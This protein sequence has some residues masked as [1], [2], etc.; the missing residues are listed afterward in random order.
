[1]QR[2]SAK[3]QACCESPYPRDEVPLKWFYKNPEDPNSKICK[4]CWHCRQYTSRHKKL[5]GAIKKEA[6]MKIKEELAKSN[7]NVSHCTALHHTYK[8]VSEYPRSE[9]PIELFRKN[10]KDPK[11]M[12][13]E[14]CLDCRTDDTKRARKSITNRREAAAESGKTLCVAC[15]DEIVPDNTAFNLNGTVSK[16]CIYC[17][18]KGKMIKDKLRMLYKTIILERIKEHEC[19]CFKCKCLFIKPD[20]DSLVVERIQTYEKEGHRYFK[21][22]DVELSVLSVF[23]DIKDNLELLVIELDHLTEEEQRSRGILRPTDPYMPKLM[24]VSHCTGEESMRLE[25]VKTQHLCHLCHIKESMARQSHPAGT[26]LSKAGQIKYEHLL[27]VKSEGCSSCGYKTDYFHRFLE[28]DH[29]DP[30]LKSFSISDGVK[31]NSIKLS[32]FVEECNKCR[33]LCRFCHR[34]H[35]RNQIRN[36]LIKRADHH[37]LDEEFSEDV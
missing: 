21:C 29:L 13:Y 18:T 30:K 24:N 9:V 25:A 20:G 34:V 26:S 3:H 5:K 1:M 31:D 35:T 16:S 36:G 32:Q 37:P 6:G 33:V 23:D 15:L 11:S 17:K 12:L 28:M 7:S 10:P 4:I 27:E 8:G 19:S 14:H 22:G 2:C